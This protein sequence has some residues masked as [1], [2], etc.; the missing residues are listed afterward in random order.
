MIQRII[1]RK[2]D[3][4]IPPINIGP[5]L[6]KYSHFFLGQSKKCLKFP[7]RKERAV[8]SSI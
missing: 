6:R 8:D 4:I 1:N 5:A 2:P 3:I 7:I